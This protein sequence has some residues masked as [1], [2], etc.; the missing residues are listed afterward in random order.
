[1][2]GARFMDRDEHALAV[3]ASVFQTPGAIRSEM[4][5][6]DGEIKATDAEL[7]AAA[8]ARGFDPQGSADNDWRTFSMDWTK[9]MRPEAYAGTDK[10]IRFYVDA[11]S[12]F[13]RAWHDWHEDNKPPTFLSRPL[14]WLG[15]LAWNEAP[16]AEAYQRNLVGMRETARALGVKLYSPDPDIEGMSFA[17]PRRKG[18]G[19]AVDELARIAK[20]GLYGALG[21]AGVIGI[22]EAVNIA[23]SK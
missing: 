21:I 6:I 22:A 16:T 10:V 20:Y 19:D 17:D 12:P 13:R 7:E 3:G 8:R 18:V 1:M 2:R 15:S 14:S 23:R 9:K 11:W 4:E 5:K